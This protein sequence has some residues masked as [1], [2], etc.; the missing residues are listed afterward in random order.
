MEHAW[1]I[2]RISMGYTWSGWIN[3]NLDFILSDTRTHRSNSI[4]SQPDL[5]KKYITTRL[6]QETEMSY[7]DKFIE[8]SELRK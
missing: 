5:D 1:A 3:M 8:R 2:C 6:R 7:N 4:T